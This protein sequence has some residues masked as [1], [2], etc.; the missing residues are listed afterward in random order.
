MAPVPARVDD[1]HGPPLDLVEFDLDVWQ[2]R[3]LKA[4]AEEGSVRGAS[5][6]AKIVSAYHYRWLKENPDYSA[7]YQQAR[8]MYSDIAEGEIRQ[9]GIAGWEK[10]LHYKGK[11]TGDKIREYS[12]TLALAVI[13]AL[14]PEYRDGQQ[15]AVGPAK[16]AIEIVNSAGNLTPGSTGSIEVNL[17]EIKQLPA[18][19]N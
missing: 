7:A 10:P 18:S 12:D 1:D 5:R 6:K 15:I 19:E 4:Y 3:W 2:R 9:R 8:E 16:I 17:S 11:L 14:K 13:K